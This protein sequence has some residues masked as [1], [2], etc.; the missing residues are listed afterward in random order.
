MSNRFKFRRGRLAALTLVAMFSFAAVPVAANAAVNLATVQPFVVL[1][2][3]TVTNTGPSVLNGALGVAPGTSLTGFGLP[4]VVNGAVHVNN[5]VATQ[6]QAD[7][8]TAYNVAAGQPV[9]PGNELTGTDLGSRTLTAG[10]Y[11]FTSS[12]QLTG[13]LTLDAQGDP[14][15]EFIFKIGSTLTTASA[16]SIIL[17]NGASP[18]NVY[19][20]VGSSA[21]LDSGTTFVGNLMALEDI[22]LNDAVTVT[23]RVLAR[24][25]QISLINDVLSNAGCATGSSGTP[26]SST[27]AGTTTTTPK[28]AKAKA[29]DNSNG[30]ARLGRGKVGPSGVR[31]TVRGTRI[32]NVTFTVDGKRV[33]GNTARQVRVAAGPGS[34]VVTAKVTFGDNTKAKEMS[35]RFRVPFPILAPRNGPSQFT[36]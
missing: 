16:S 20:Q 33:K 5:G 2:G 21:T 26:T 23:G 30:T 34:H 22:S 31:A 32:K 18:C 24:N 10:V 35:F 19:W 7:L 27:P 14:S 9:P 13:Q 29:K 28:K 17:T 36:G 8:T 11:G 15:A 12:A 1:G 3:S 6:A 4:A 25:G